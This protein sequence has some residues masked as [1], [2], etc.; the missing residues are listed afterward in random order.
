MDTALYGIPLA[1]LIVALV[2]LAKRQGL[3]DQRAPLIAVG[4][5]VLFMILGRLDQ[6]VLGTWYEVVLH[7]L[8]VGLTACGLYSGGRAVAGR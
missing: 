3:P 6:P 5:G 2:E 8:V 4:L 1:L 7:G